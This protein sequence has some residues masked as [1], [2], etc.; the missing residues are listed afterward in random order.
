MHFISVMDF[1]NVMNVSIPMNS[2]NVIF[3]INSYQN[4]QIKIGKNFINGLSVIQMN[5]FL[6]YWWFSSNWFIP[7]RWA[8]W[9]SA[10]LLSRWQLHQGEGFNQDNKI[11]QENE[12]MKVIRFIIYQGKS[13]YWRGIYPRWMHFTWNVKVTFSSI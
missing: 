1:I 2:I 11:N 13:F 9:L 7:S 4:Y 8:T 3:F 12:W 5:K 6:L 10:W